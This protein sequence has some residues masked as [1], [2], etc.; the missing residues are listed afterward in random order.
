LAMNKRTATNWDGWSV[1]ANL[2]SVKMPAL[3]RP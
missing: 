3:T 1:Y 2:L